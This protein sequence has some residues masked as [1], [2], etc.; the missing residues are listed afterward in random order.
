MKHIIQGKRLVSLRYFSMFLMQMQIVFQLKI[1][2]KR[3]SKT[4]TNESV[5]VIETLD[6]TFLIMMWTTYLK[7]SSSGLSLWVCLKRRLRN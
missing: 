1:I 7:E 5:F 6:D 3:Q 2:L 4:Y